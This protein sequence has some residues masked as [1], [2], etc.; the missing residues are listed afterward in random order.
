MSRCRSNANIITDHPEVRRTI[1]CSR[2]PPRRAAT[3]V[4]LIMGITVMMIVLTLAVS[5]ITRLQRGYG[6]V[7]AAMDLRARL[8]DGAD[9]VAADVRGIAPAGDSILV[10]SDTALEFYSAIGSSTLC[11]MPALIR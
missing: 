9:I 6:A 10:A 5:Q 8:R 2:M 4:E 7:N 1:K 11:T 3:L